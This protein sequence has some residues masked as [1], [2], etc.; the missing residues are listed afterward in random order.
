MPNY[1]C[2]G[3]YCAECQAT[4]TYANDVYGC[5][6]IAYYDNVVNRCTG[7]STVTCPNCEESMWRDH[8]FLNTLIPT[9][10]PTVAQVPESTM[11]GIY[12]YLSSNPVP[13]FPPNGPREQLFYAYPGDGSPMA[14]AVQA[15]RVQCSCAACGRYR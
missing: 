5:N 14:I 12:S 15:Q 13:A 4:F 6:N 11:G 1:S 8:R 9:R 10:V 2:L 7:R 3:H